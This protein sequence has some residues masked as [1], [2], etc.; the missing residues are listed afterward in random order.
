MLNKTYFKLKKKNKNNNEYT[1][2]KIEVYNVVIACFL[3]GL[4]KN[5][6]AAIVANNIRRSFL[7][8][9]S[10]IVNIKKSV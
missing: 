4:I 8:K 7:I 1:L 9:F 2:S 10:F 6:P 3:A 5:S